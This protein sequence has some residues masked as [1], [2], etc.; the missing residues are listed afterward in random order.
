M[1]SVKVICNTC[2]FELHGHDQLTQHY[3]SEWHR[4]NLKRKASDL[5]PVNVENFKNRLRELERQ[6]TEK[7]RKNIFKCPYS[8][9]IFKSQGAWDSY[10]KSKKY[11]ELVLKFQKT[12]G[13]TE[14]RAAV[15]PTI[16]QLTQK[17]QKLWQKGDSP[18]KRWLYQQYIKAGEDEDNW[19]DV[20]DD[21][22]EEDISTQ[23]DAQMDDISE[24]EGIEN[25]ESIYGPA[26][27]KLE[28]IKPLTDF[29]DNKN[30]KSFKN[31]DQLLNHLETKYGFHLPESK[32]IHSVD[33]LLAYICEKIGLGLT[34]IHC[35]KGFYSLEAVQQH[36]RETQPHVRLNIYGDHAFEFAEFYNFDQL[37]DEEVNVDDFD[38]E[39]MQL[40]LPSGVK[41]GHKDMAKYYKQSYSFI[42]VGMENSV[43]GQNR[44]KQIKSGRS[45]F[46]PVKA[47]GWNNT[48]ASVKQTSRDI[49]FVHK[50]RKNQYMKLG[51]K[52]NKVK[53]T[54]F[55]KQMMNCG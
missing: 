20:S 35:N 27:I 41:L 5:P 50:L 10:L 11:R 49:R 33:K 44:I 3:K 15:K 1:D 34:C 39:N 17:K 53:Q 2:V 14:E 51:I 21:D 30:S 43:Y 4:Y 12:T 6:Q 26:P 47:I 42:P 36:M 16:E 28:A 38:I 25:P 45:L 46:N 18:Q 52:H 40:I 55:R 54:H 7:D 48:V 32:Y 23:H 37:E 29:F 13:E 9:K 31:S 8:G 19:E 24:D 22:M